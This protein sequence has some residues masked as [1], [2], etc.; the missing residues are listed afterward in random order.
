MTIETS[1]RFT[2]IPAPA[3]SKEIQ[4]AHHFT[5]VIADYIACLCLAKEERLEPCY[6][7]EN[8]R[9][10]RDFFTE[11]VTVTPDRHSVQLIVFLVPRSGSSQSDAQ[12]TQGSP[13]MNADQDVGNKG[14][15]SIIRGEWISRHMGM[16]HTPKGVNM[17]RLGSTEL[18]RTR[19]S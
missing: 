9:L 4:C 12:L 13:K 2:T 19:L 16:T 11:A 1:D 17:C 7:L 10:F 3:S 6:R 14:S 15:R 8:L 5:S 18:L